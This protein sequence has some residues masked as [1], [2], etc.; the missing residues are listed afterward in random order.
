MNKIKSNVRSKLRITDPCHKSAWRK[1]EEGEELTEAMLAVRV[2]TLQGGS[3]GRI[4]D[5]V[6]P[7]WRISSNI[8]HIMPFP[9]PFTEDETGWLSEYRGDD[10][11]A[12]SDIYLVTFTFWYKYLGCERIGVWRLYFDEKQCKWCAVPNDGTVIAYRPLPELPEI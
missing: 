1:P 6:Y 8:T 10:P 11:P 4:V 12:K 9:P 2:I 5:T 3:K 7:T